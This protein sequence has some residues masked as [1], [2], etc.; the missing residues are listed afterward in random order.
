MNRSNFV[1][2]LEKIPVI[3]VDLIRLE[4]NKQPPKALRAGCVTRPSLED[5]FRPSA[6]D[7]CIT[8]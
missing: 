5:R 2:T 4:S 7:A 8:G 1:L 6:L 3:P